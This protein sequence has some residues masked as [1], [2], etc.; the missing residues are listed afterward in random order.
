MDSFEI[1]LETSRNENLQ[2]SKDLETSN[3]EFQLSLA[4]SAGEAG[5]SKETIHNLKTMLDKHKN[6][7]SKISKEL[8][9][10]MQ[11]FK[12][13]LVAW[14]E[15][16]RVLRQKSPRRQQTPKQHCVNS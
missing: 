4:A 5:R 1:L 2:L 12:E 16:T 8:E 6:E 13:A 9:H 14:R 7:N 10:S 3:Q 11:L 15:K